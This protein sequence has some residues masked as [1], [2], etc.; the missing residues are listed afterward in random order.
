MSTAKKTFVLIALIVAI[1]LV[2]IL[3]NSTGCKGDKCQSATP[4][5]APTPTTQLTIAQQVT[6]TGGTLI[7]VRTPEEFAESHAK[8]AIN[9]PLVDIQ[10]GIYPNIA[11]NQPI[12]VYCRTGSRARQ[13]VRI[14]EQNGFINTTDI[15]SLADW[16]KQGGEVVS[17]ELPS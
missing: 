14:L 6:D 11:R 17:S 5:P 3:L 13:A 2:A 8:N 16:Q 4:A 15:G 7:D 9:L 10:H 12:Y 1:I